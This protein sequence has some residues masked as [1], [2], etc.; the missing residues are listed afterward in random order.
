MTPVQRVTQPNL[1]PTL[2][3]ERRTSDGFFAPTVLRSML[4]LSGAA[5]PADP[6]LARL[7]DEELVLLRAALMALAVTDPTSVA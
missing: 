3:G 5:H 2:S 1:I 4:L 6:T 7:S